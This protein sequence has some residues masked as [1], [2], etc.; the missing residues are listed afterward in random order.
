MLEAIDLAIEL[1]IE[2]LKLNCVLMAGTNDDE[3]FD[4]AAL[5]EQQ[6][7]VRFIEYMPFDGNRWE[8][9]NAWCPSIRC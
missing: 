4:F 8:E 6:I 5:S 3:L 9:E 2:P 7:D 1:G